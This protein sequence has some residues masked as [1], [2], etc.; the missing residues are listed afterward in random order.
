M[1]R[2]VKC[3]NIKEKVTLHTLRHTF[4]SVLVRR[5]VGIEVV[6]SLMGHANISITYQKYIHVVQEQKAKAM[7][8]VSVC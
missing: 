6:S 7:S 2:I 5:G 4:G 3:T 8:M 1:D